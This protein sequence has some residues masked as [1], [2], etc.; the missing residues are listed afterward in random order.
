MGKSKR[1]G[2]VAKVQTARD[3][4]K[5]QADLVKRAKKQMAEDASWEDNS[6][7][8][9]K[10]QERKEQRERKQQSA[11]ERKAAN[12][13]LAAEDEASTKQ[14]TKRVNGGQTKVT[15]AQL[16]ADKVKRDAAARQRSTEQA[17][18][19]NNITV[20]SQDEIEENPNQAMARMVSD[21]D[22]L[23]AR[24]VDAAIAL[25]Q[26]KAI[27]QEKNQDKRVR[28]AFL[29]YERDNLPRIK[30]E[31]PSLRLSQVKAILRKDWNRSSENPSKSY[32]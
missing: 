11:A 12:R 10:A 16:L 19:R 21:D 22:G 27:E 9:K 8:L 17:A 29:A 20:F 28:I 24:D 2:P 3:K 23:E 15:R 6:K 18:T 7:S 26:G 13:A 5:T 31:N 30:A 14:Q 1:G 32:R 4:K 25:L